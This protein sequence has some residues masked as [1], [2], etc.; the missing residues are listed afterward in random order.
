M[1][2]TKPRVTPPPHPKSLENGYF[3][4]NIIKLLVMQV[5]FREGSG[6]SFSVL[7]GILQTT[8]TPL[9]FIDNLRS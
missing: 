8:K 4:L 2:S 1:F 5:I 7:G 9:K 6:S 3:A